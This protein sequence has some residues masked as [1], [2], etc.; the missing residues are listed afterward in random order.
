MRLI[1]IGY[2]QD[3]P[4]FIQDYGIKDEI[5][6]IYESMEILSK[7]SLL[8]L[9]TRQGAESSLPQRIY[10]WQTDHRIWMWLISSGF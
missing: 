2:V 5:A 6:R 9:W 7:V 8:D 4:D 3:S 1:A 10:L